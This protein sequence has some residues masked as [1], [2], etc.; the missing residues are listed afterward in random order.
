MYMR[1]IS[2]PVWWQQRYPELL[3]LIQQA[4]KVG[5]AFCK[6]YCKATNFAWCEDPKEGLTC[7]IPYILSN[8]TDKELEKK[9]TDYMNEYL[10]RTSS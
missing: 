10:F 3:K 7:Q 6:V 9:I 8:L 2:G 4:W 1:T 5:D